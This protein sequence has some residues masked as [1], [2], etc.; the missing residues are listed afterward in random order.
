MG[1][2]TLDVR[3]YGRLLARTV[4]KVIEN[5]EEYERLLSEVEQLMDRGDHRTAEE[6]ALLSL[7]VSL[8]QAY[9]QRHYPM[10]EVS[11]HEVLRYLMEK[12]G[13]KQADLVPIFRSSGYVSDVINGKRAIS[14]AHAR[15]LASFFGVSAELFI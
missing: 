10:G 14:K 12:R 2:L 5:E 11:A 6:D 4:P 7:L 3:R 9:E 15:K 8:I 1:A 13:L